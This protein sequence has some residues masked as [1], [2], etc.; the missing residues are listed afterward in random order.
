MSEN[1][2][3]ELKLIG[4]LW[5]RQSEKGT[6]YFKGKM[7]DE[8]I[9]IFKNNKPKN[10]NSPNYFLFKEVEINEVP[11]LNTDGENDQLPLQ[12]DDLPF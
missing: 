12:D 11:V 7:G 6:K 1:K 8:N 2:N 5:L 10:E 9:I 4:S 3:D